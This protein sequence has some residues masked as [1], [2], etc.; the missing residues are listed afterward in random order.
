MLGFSLHSPKN[1]NT[2]NSCQAARHN[3]SPLK[4]T[5]LKSLDVVGYG[6]GYRCCAISK[7]TIMANFIDYLVDE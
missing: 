4:H 6:N 2:L 3:S 1:K 7:N 5:Q